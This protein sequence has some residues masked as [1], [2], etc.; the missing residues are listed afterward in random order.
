MAKKQ[1]IILADRFLNWACDMLH[2]QNLQRTDGRTMLQLKYL[3]LIHY[4]TQ[5]LQNS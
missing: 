3:S 2:V 5:A 1:V 4:S